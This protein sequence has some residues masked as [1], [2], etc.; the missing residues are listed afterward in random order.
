MAANLSR[1]GDCM[2]FG[3]RWRLGFSALEFV[4]KSQKR[5]LTT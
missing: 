4:L 5:S 1:H 3:V 2:I